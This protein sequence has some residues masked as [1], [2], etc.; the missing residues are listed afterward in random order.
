[1]TT[2]DLERHRRER[3]RQAESLAEARGEMLTRAVRLL[4]IAC[5]LAA[6]T[7]CSWTTVMAIVEL[8]DELEQNPPATIDNAEL[9]E[10]LGG[11]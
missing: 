2:F 1:V 9:L 5:Q 4:G 3:L 11:P 10:L 8:V 6:G 7:Q